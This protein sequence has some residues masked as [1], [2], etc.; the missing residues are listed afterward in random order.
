MKMLKSLHINC[1]S[2]EGILP[3][4]SDDILEPNH[5]VQLEQILVQLDGVQHHHLT[6]NYQFINQL[7]NLL[8]NYILTLLT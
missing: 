1:S 8:T 2:I 6:I 3:V 7:S 4:G 5:P